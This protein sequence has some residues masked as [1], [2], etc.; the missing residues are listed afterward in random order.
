MGLLQ[1]PIWATYAY[2]KQEGSNWSEKLVSSF[3]P[4]S[5][6]G[7]TDP[8]LNEN[9]KKFLINEKNKDMFKNTGI[10]YRMKRHIYG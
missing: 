4:T 1:I 10:L 3:Q 8:V 2:L 9:Y 5:N 6:W 7:P